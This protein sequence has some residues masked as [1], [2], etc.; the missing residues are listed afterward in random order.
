[1]RRDHFEDQSVYGRKIFVK[2][3][4][5]RGVYSTGTWLDNF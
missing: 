5:K 4:W 3:L 1:M 2:R